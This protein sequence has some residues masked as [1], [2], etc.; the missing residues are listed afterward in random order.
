MGRG[1]RGGDQN[2][3]MTAAAFLFSQHLATAAAATA[4][5]PCSVLSSVEHQMTGRLSLSLS[6][7]CYGSRWKVCL[8]GELWQGLTTKRNQITDDAA[9]SR[10]SAA[11]L[12]L[13]SCFQLGEK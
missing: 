3:M 1:G 2:K 13:K 11:R 6:A 12:H 7:G 8:V 4:A 9:P 10:L 5:A